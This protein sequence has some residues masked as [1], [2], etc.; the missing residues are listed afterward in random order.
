MRIWGD[1]FQRCSCVWRRFSRHCWVFQ[2]IF[3]GFWQ[4]C[5]GFFVGI[6]GG[7]RRV[8]GGCGGSQMCY[9]WGPTV[10]EGVFGG[11]PR[12]FRWF[13]DIPLQ[14]FLNPKTYVI[15]LK[16]PQ[17]LF[18]MPLKLLGF[19]G[20]TETPWCD[21]D[22]KCLETPPKSPS[23]HWTALEIFMINLKFFWNFLECLWKARRKNQ[24]NTLKPLETPLK[25]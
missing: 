21:S 3:D 25:C 20:I 9:T 17:N 19:K 12:N 16:C 2:K 23:S 15:R 14:N 7:F 4:R 5:R 10:F 6:L 11:I 22:L 8:F 18:K 1:L 13:S 24:K